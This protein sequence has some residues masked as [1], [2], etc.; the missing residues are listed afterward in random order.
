[1]IMN[2]LSQLAKMTTLVADTGDLPAIIRLKPIDATT[3]PSLITS[4]FISGEYDDIIYSTKHLTTD[5]AIDYLTVWLGKLILEH[6]TGRVSTEVDAKL[7]FDTQ[8]PLQKPCN[9]LT[10]MKNWALKRTNFNQDCR[11]MAR[12]RSRKNPRTA[13]YSL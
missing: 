4:A 3:N 8:K 11:N 5:E 7:S 6:I 9:L 10:L 1:M 13:R 2:T 12:H